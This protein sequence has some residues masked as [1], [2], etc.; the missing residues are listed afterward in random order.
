[1]VRLTILT[2]LNRTEVLKWFGITEPNRLRFGTNRTEP[3][4][5]F[6]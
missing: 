5:W 2:E 3:K 6:G 1:M 4:L